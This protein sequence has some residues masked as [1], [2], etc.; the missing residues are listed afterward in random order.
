[1]DNEQLYYV[2][3]GSKPT[4]EEEYNIKTKINQ[5][6]LQDNNWQ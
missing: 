5:L 6:K 3:N 1:V 2:T 4:K